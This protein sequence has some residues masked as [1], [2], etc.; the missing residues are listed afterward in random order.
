MATADL[1]YGY[2]L[3]QNY[4]KAL[5]L[6][7]EAEAINQQGAIPAPWVEE[8]VLADES[9]VYVEQGNSLGLKTADKALAL[10]RSQQDLRW[11][12]ICLWVEAFAYL[13]FGELQKSEDAARQALAILQQLG[14]K[15]MESRTW[16]TLGL[17]AE[18]RHDRK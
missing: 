16:D 5:S 17:L 9:V 11:T 7:K 1:G 14:E 3:E 2:L 4:D 18:A 13:H 12:G 6:L 15:D 8:V 10:A